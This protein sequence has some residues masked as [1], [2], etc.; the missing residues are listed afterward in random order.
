[1][2]WFPAL[3]L[4]LVGLG[5]S[6]PKPTM[7]LRFHEQVP[8]N[9]PESRVRFVT[10][11]RTGERIAVN[12]YPAIAERD[13]LSAEIQSGPGGNAVLLKFDSH[14]A[15]VLN[16]MTTRMRGQHLVVLMD[17]KPVAA[18]L[19]ERIIMNGQFLL[20]GDMTD[21]EAVALAAALNEYS[22]RRRD[23]GDT[24]FAP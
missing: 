12:P 4:V 14:G 7:T 22:G 6:A 18:V 13:V 2:K 23:F 9:L 20:F 21:A 8:G 16:E 19:I 3:L 11:D 10:L 24:R 17:D 1:V 15:N 5:C